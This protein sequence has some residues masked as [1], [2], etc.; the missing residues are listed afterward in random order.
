[1]KFPHDANPNLPP[2]H[3]CP[4]Y[5]CTCDS[6]SL[7]VIVASLATTSPASISNMKT[8]EANNCLMLTVFG[9]LL[10]LPAIAATRYVNLNNTTAASPY[11]S[12]TTAATNLQQ[13]VDASSDGDLVLVTNGVYQ[14]GGRVAYGSLTNRV[15]VNRPISVQSVNGP[16][17]T[18]IQGFQIPGV[19]NGDSAVRCV[20]LTNGASLIGFT[21]RQGATRD[22]GHTIYERSGG[23]V[24]CE[25]TNVVVSNCV[26]VANSCVWL[27]A[28]AYSGM[29]ENCALSNNWNYNVSGAGGGGASNGR[30]RFCRFEANHAATGGGTQ[31]GFLDSC[32]V[33][34]N[35]AT[36]GGGSGGGCSSSFLVN[37]MVAGNRSMYGGG[38]LAQGTATG[39]TISDNSSRNGGGTS[40]TALRNC[41]IHNNSATETGGGMLNGSATN[42]TI[43]G[44][45]AYI[46]GG[47]HSV[48]HHNSLIY[49]NE[50]NKG[51]NHLNGTFYDSCT[52]P[53]PT[54]GNGNFASEP[55]LAG[56]F[57]LSLDSP[58]R[59]AGKVGSAT[60]LD[61]DAQPWANPPS[62]GCDEPVQ[63]AQIGPLSIWIQAEYT[64]VAA[65]F[66]IKLT[67][68]IEGQPWES[69]W[70]FG[71]GTRLTNRPFA[72]H[73]WISPGDYTV[74]LTAYNGLNPGGTSAAITI[75]VLPPPIHYVVTTNPTPSPPYTT[76]ST[77]ATNIQ[78]AID[79]ASAAG[80]VVLVSNGVYEVGG[81][82]VYGALTNRI[83][84][85]KPL[86]VRSMNGPAVTHIKG[87]FVPGT[88]NGDAAIRCAY[89]GDGATLDGFTLTNGATRNTGSM[90]REQS[91]GGAWLSGAAL[92]TNCVVIGNCAP[93]G[94]GAFSGTL[95]NC[96]V[97]KNIANSGAGVYESDLMDCVIN[98]N[99][100]EYGGGAYL[101]RISSS[102]LTGNRAVFYGGGAYWTQISQSQLIGNTAGSG[103]G[104]ARS[105]V[106]S[107]LIASNFAG[108]Y[109]GGVDSSEVNQCRIIGNSAS[110]GGGGAFSS[111]IIGTLVA[112]NGAGSYG[113]GLA[114]SQL[115][116]C[117]V[118]E[119]SA[120]NNYGGG[121]YNSQATNC[122]LYNNSAPLGP[123][124]YAGQDMFFSHC[125]TQPLPSIGSENIIVAPGF[126]NLP[127]GDYRLSASSACINAGNNF[128]LT[129]TTDLDGNPRLAGGTVDIGAYEFPSP[130]SILSYAWAQRY[131]LP[132]DGSADFTDS[133]SDGHNNWQEWRA[134][135]I[136]TNSLSVL[137]L[138]GITNVPNG[139]QL[140]WLSTATRN[141]WLERSTNLTE[142]QTVQ[143]V[144]TNIAGV[145]GVK[146]FID[147]T[148]TNSGPY[149][150]RVGVQPP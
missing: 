56:P 81:R 25:S 105:A 138:T 145:T 110:F 33:V 17:V 123:N 35:S 128:A 32:T 148:A 43:T 133:D 93:A 124:H 85:T 144:A 129:N 29:L 18:V 37:C 36:G 57:H 12:W 80:A 106:S 67:G 91:G 87:Y 74:T 5:F 114:N 1:M 115:S 24:L 97:I 131:Q 42:C 15:S 76:P 3:A 58:C 10:A 61:I 48:T 44:N 119:N 132:T 45:Q 122:I 41:A 134:N 142:A 86:I 6:S 126:V 50:A 112:R 78:D 109:G 27:G 111:V 62:V 121:V 60:G 51:P 22:T 23:G 135:T 70:D 141:Y 103:A 92:L 59:G 100:A 16:L 28:G 127:G 120:T 13:A 94:G 2:S 84:I 71:D 89:V 21:L 68:L 49:Y 118:V 95:R 102:A 136:P 79:A 8:T 146:S 150:Y 14:F 99:R 9:V 34:N 46:G 83:A 147:S 66:A 90:E 31:G 113:G 77:A 72:T 116:S 125:C 96:S 140:R 130:P 69:F 108:S 38:G 40:S 63:S 101:G 53:S 11:L 7:M 104:A 82:V 75:H 149:F 117:T 26:V 143:I 39:C 20:Y 4:I 52:T 47:T 88:T 137:R 98:E 139:L 55:R 107:S 19:T 30:Y 54:N 73:A 65:A 64:N